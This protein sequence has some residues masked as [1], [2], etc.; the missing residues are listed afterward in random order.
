MNMQKWVKAVNTLGIT[1][2]VIM[3]YWVF[4]FL[5]VQVFGLKIFQQRIT[6]MFG[7]SIIGILAVMAAALMLN[8]MLNLTRI[9]ERGGTTEPTAGSKKTVW[10]FA[11]SFPVLAALLFGGNHLSTLKKRDKMLA[12]AAYIV[13]NQPPVSS[14][15]FDYAHLQTLF[16]YLEQAGENVNAEGS[17]IR[18]V[19][20]APDTLNGRPVYLAIREPS[21]WDTDAVFVGEVGDSFTVMAPARKNKRNTVA[22]SDYRHHFSSE[23]QQYL[24]KVFAENGRDIRFNGYNGDYELFYPYQRNGKTIGVLWFTDSDRYGKLGSHS[25]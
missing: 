21:D 12:D 24:N 17:G 18:V 5:L 25:K 6:D 19:W 4:A 1:A 7:L 11:L 20:V 13:Q 9:A 8:I 15:R 2:A 23:E 16:R 3:I 14:Y 10:L 22:K